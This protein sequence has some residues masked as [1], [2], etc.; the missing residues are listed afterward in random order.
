[1]PKIDI[2]AAPV[3]TGT[4]YPAPFDAPTIVVGGLEMYEARC[5]ACYEGVAA[6]RAV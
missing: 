5:R 2:A 4:G 3:R 1:M 6:Q